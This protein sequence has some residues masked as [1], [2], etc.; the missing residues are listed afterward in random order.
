VAGTGVAL[1]KL[2]PPGGHG[3]FGDEVCPSHFSKQFRKV[4][5]AKFIYEIL[6]SPGPMEPKTSDRPASVPNPKLYMPLR[7]I[8]MRPPA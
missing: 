8:K 2:A 4:N 5:S 6:H 1:A 7:R 3:G